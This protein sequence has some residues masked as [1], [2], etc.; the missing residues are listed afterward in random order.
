MQPTKLTQA[1]V[2]TCDADTLAAALRAGAADVANR[3]GAVEILADFGD[4]LMRTKIRDH[5]IVDETGRAHMQWRNLHI[6]AT[7]ENNVGHLSSTAQRALLFAC[8]LGAGTPMVSLNEAVASWG[9]V[10]RVTAV[11]A[12]AIACDQPDHAATV[13]RINDLVQALAVYGDRTLSARGAGALIASVLIGSHIRTVPEVIGYQDLDW[14][15][16]TPEEAKLKADALAAVHTNANLTAEHG[17]LTVAGLDAQVLDVIT[18]A[19]TDGISADEVAAR[20]PSNVPANIINAALVRLVR[21]GGTVIYNAGT[22]RYYPLGYA[23]TALPLTDAIVEI[24]RASTCDPHSVRPGGASTDGL[25]EILLTDHHI[26]A[27]RLDV[28]AAC[29]ELAARGLVEQPEAHGPYYLTGYAPTGTTTTTTGP[30]TPFE[31]P[32]TLNREQLDALVRDN[33]TAAGRDGLTLPAILTVVTAAQGGRM[34]SSGV[35]LAAIDRIGATAV[36]GP[37]GTIEIRWTL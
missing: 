5:I 25:I 13:N 34:A 12:F 6:A 10:N 3:L 15:T 21:P 20:I 9:T 32:P 30:A 31:Q 35:V 16:T 2:A 33:L 22:R 23:P 7:I 11:R 36:D 26:T 14:T 24:L 27:T 28:A 29:G 4:L 8:A 19:G 18:V 1:D 17:S 37:P